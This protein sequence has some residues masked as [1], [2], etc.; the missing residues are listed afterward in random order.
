MSDS[1]RPSNGSPHPSFWIRELPFFAVLA[2]TIIGIAYTSFSKQPI[3]AYWDVLG[4][5]VGLVCVGS[6]WH[7]AAD[8]TARV[9]LMVTQA[10]H[11]IAFLAAMNMML[12]PVVQRNFSANAT[13]LAVFTLLALGTF[14]AGVHVLSWQVC[15]LGVIMALGIPAIAWIENSTLLVVIIAGVII[16]TGSVLWWHWRGSRAHG[17]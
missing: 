6:G 5:I 16:A 1:P 7:A 14:T 12:L 10:L 13:G 15:L 3:A 2:L 9:R 17:A 11:W 8:K 4:P